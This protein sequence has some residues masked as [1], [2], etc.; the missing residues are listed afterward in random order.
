MKIN[1]HDIPNEYKE[2]HNEAIEVL[3]QIKDGKVLS[4]N[5]EL[6]VN[7]LRGHDAVAEDWGAD[8]EQFREN[9][10]Q[11]KGYAI[12]LV[13]HSLDYQFDFPRDEKPYELDNEMYAKHIVEKSL[14]DAYGVISPDTIEDFN[15]GFEK[16]FRQPLHYY[17]PT[18][19]YDVGYTVT[20]FENKEDELSNTDYFSLKDSFESHGYKPTDVLINK[21]GVELR[22]DVPENVLLGETNLNRSLKGRGLDISD[23]ELEKQSNEMAL[24][25]YEQ[26]K[27]KADATKNINPVKPTKHVD[28]PDYYDVPED[29]AVFDAYSGNKVP[30][31]RFEKMELLIS[32]I[33][34]NNIHPSFEDVGESL[35]HTNV[36]IRTD[37]TSFES[38]ELANDQDLFK[39]YMGTLVAD[40]LNE[41]HK[42][43][44][45]QSSYQYGILA[46]ERALGDREGNIS[47]K[48]AREFID[49]FGKSFRQSFDEQY[50]EEEM[51]N[52]YTDYE[53]EM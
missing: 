47:P 1:I 46:T 44:N 38:D 37:F 8:I 13:S 39:N 33:R 30:Y 22:K 53:P 2:L 35:K 21:V 7:M 32:Q 25:H 4:Q 28:K 24:P 50:T 12:D 18:V 31:E 16:S 48:V 27:I 9:P 49:G 34:N 19:E 23:A 52:P 36:R 3:S 14:G 42:E 29:R 45:M 26:M 5:S 41:Y 20:T 11:F 10:E 17:G 43:D 15:K 40:S 51:F 6:A